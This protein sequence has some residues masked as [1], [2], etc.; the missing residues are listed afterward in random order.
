MLSATEAGT[1]WKPSSGRVAAAT[2]RATGFAAKNATMLAAP[3]PLRKPRRL[4]PASIRRLNSGSCSRGWLALSLSSKRL[5]GFSLLSQRNH[6]VI[7]ASG[8]SMAALY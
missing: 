5:I 4:R 1:A 6:C 7:T 8:H 2:A 3:T